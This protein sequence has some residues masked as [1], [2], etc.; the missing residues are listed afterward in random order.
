MTLKRLSVT[1]FSE[2]RARR[3]PIVVVTAYDH[4]QALAADEAG[5]DAI[6]VGDS[7]A[8]TTLGRPDTLS[9]SMD[10]M[11]HHTKAVS[12]AVQHAMVI[13]DMPFMSYQTGTRDALKNAARFLKEPGPKP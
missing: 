12:Q 5:V 3:E 4:P 7:V 8:N 10:E 6:L 9:M 1:T 2:K 13:G 11:V